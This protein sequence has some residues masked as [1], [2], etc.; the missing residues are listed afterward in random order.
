MNTLPDLRPCDHNRHL[1]VGID[2]DEGVWHERSWRR[3]PNRGKGDSNQKTTTGG[4]ANLAEMA[5]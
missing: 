1:A 4:D 3:P 2:S 5:A